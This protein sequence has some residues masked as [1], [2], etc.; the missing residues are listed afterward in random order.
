MNTEEKLQVLAALL[1]E[2][3]GAVRIKDGC[4]LFQGKKALFGIL[5]LKTIY[6]D[7]DNKITSFRMQWLEKGA[8]DGPEADVAMAQNRLIEN[9]QSAFPQ[10][11]V[12]NPA[13]IKQCVRIALQVQLNHYKQLEA[14]EGVFITKPGWHT[15]RNDELVYYVG[16]IRCAVHTETVGMADSLKKYRVPER[17]TAIAQQQECDIIMELA[18]IPCPPLH[19]A[20]LFQIA[21]IIKP[22]MERAG[23]IDRNPI[24]YLYGEAGSGKTRLLRLVNSLYLRNDGDREIFEIPLRSWKNSLYGGMQEASGTVVILDDLA[25]SNG[26]Q[27]EQD[28]KKLK[29]LIMAL[30]NGALPL[31]GTEGKESRVDFLAAVTANSIL[32]YTLE[33]LERIC[34]VCVGQGDIPFERIQQITGSDPSPLAGIYLQLIRHIVS[35]QDGLV[36][37]MRFGANNDQS[38]YWDIVREKDEDGEYEELDFYGYS[39]P[40]SGIRDLMREWDLHSYDPA[41]QFSV[42]SVTLQ[43]M[44]ELDTDMDLSWY[45]LLTCKSVCDSNYKV[46]E[47]TPDKC[48]IGCK[49]H[50]ITVKIERDYGN[51]RLI[52]KLKEGRRA[53]KDYNQA[54]KVISPYET[55]NHY[56]D[57]GEDLISALWRMVLKNTGDYLHR[58]DL[59]KKL[60]EV[61]PKRAS[62][63]AEVADRWNSYAD[64]EKAE[65]DILADMVA[66]GRTPAAARK[67]LTDYREA[68]ARAGVSM[69][70]L[71]DDV[72]V[73]QMPSVWTL[74]EGEKRAS[75]EEFRRELQERYESTLMERLRNGPCDGEC[76]QCQKKAEEEYEEL[77][78]S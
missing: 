77:C 9:L 62:E 74:L 20:F 73:A 39:D 64:R 69:V 66:E 18:K 78:N 57:N 54:E 44:V 61:Y 51:P 12:E 22:L 35:K 21:A 47:L 25:G 50:K 24:L 42:R 31:R 37:S 26:V 11:L 8:V 4:M 63:L 40:E 15:D 52:F 41:Q 68:F 72:P 55:L 71:P 59:H 2:N 45:L 70:Y 1:E 76:E 56:Y 14:S 65:M 17:A 10:M 53:I 58:D 33:I 38:V 16:P 3:C 27:S 19:M 32:D 6:R 34:I 36:R 28:A 60:R 7:D 46:Q 67:K 13:R 23:I 5:V 48:V 43:A 29:E 49:S 75:Y 30:G